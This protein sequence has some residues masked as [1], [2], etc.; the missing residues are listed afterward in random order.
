MS[1]IALRGREDEP[2][3]RALLGPAAP[4]ASWPA[5]ARTASSTRAATVLV[6]RDR[7]ERLARRVRARLGR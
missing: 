4:A 6:A 5:G 3:V 7:C 1:L 2:A